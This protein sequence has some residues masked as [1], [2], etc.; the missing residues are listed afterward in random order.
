VTVHKQPLRREFS[1]KAPADFKIFTVYQVPDF[2]APAKTGF[3]HGFLFAGETRQVKTNMAATLP[4]ATVR[5]G[6]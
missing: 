4:W 1:R 3:L 2:I 6:T 5:Y